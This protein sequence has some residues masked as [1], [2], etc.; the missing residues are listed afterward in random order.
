MKMTIN[1]SLKISIVTPCYNSSKFIYRL[2]ESLCRQG[3]RNFEW[4]LIDDLS[5]DN[6]LEVLKSLRSPGE[7]GISIYKLPQNSGGGVAI[8]FGIERCKGDIVI[9]IDHDDELVESAFNTIISEWDKVAKRPEM[10][11][12]F[13]R[14]LDPISG[15]VLGENLDAGIEFSMSWLSNTIPSISDGFF[16]FKNLVVK[17]YFNPKS[18]EAICLLG[19]PLHY[20]TK[21][22]KL[23]AGS[24][25]PLLIY[26]RDNRSSQ[27]N[28]VKISHKTV[29][30]YAKYIEAYDRLYFKRPLYWIRHIIALINFSILVH[31]NP[32]YHHRFIDSSFI[33]FMSFILLPVGYLSCI[34]SKDKTTVIDLPLFDLKVLEN[35]SDLKL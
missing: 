19:V 7:G 25:Q 35:I 3:F 32:T 18:L 34:H 24:I 27:T 20:M 2:H 11:G 33:K 28:F 26:H 9:I 1:N 23:L 14:R 4:I 12:I 5:T 17:E 16:V 29:Y 22:Y 8:G 13:Y 6:T 15:K 21:K 30:T 31:R 10:A